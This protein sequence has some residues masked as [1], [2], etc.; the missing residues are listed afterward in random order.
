VGGDLHAIG[1]HHLECSLHLTVGFG[2]I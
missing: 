2:N 1:H